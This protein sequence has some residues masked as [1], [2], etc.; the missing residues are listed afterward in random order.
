MSGTLLTLGTGDKAAWAASLAASG[1]A[2]PFYDA[3]VLEFLAASEHAKAELLVFEHGVHRVVMPWLLRDLPQ[4]VAAAAG[5]AFCR[6]AFGPDYAGP[7]ASGGTP[8]EVLQE[9][10]AAL[11]AHA[12]AT[13]TLSLFLRLNPFDDEQSGL[14]EGDG[15]RVDREV[16]WVNLARG[17]DG[18]W[19]NFSSAARKNYKRSVA[20]G[21]NITLSDGAEHLD[22]FARIYAS[23]MERREAQPR[24]R[25]DRDW[26]AGLLEAAR[27]RTLMVTAWKGNDPIASHLYLRGGG[28]AFSYLGGAGTEHWNDRPTNAVVTAAIRALSEGGNLRLI[29]G[30][31]YQPGDGI[32]NFKRSFSPLAATFRTLR[33]VF[34]RDAYLAASGPTASSTL[35]G[36]FPAYR[37]P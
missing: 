26:F 12:R 32:E 34:D 11:D 23:T 30:G 31:G 35:D 19:T 1:G 29:L 4:G 8:R 36:F 27:G 5:G 33:R 3:D 20:V 25:F 22:G 17:F 28:Y 21:L 10:W 9:F 18:A 16:I 7:K 24:Y 2:H 14:D 37:A 15:A 6:D 13:G